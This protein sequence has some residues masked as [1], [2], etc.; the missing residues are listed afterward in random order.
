[1]G[2]RCAVVG[3]SVRRILGMI[4]CRMTLKLALLTGACGLGVYLMQGFNPPMSGRDLRVQHEDA[5][6]MTP[7]ETA[8]YRR[9]MAERGW[10]PEV[11]AA[12]PSNA[13][14]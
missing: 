4:P 3:A 13:S 10:V 6:R 12:T 1:M 9:L 2:D 7:A 14:R 5:R 11:V 8:E